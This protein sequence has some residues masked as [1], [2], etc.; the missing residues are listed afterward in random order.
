MVAH[1]VRF[2]WIPAHMTNIHTLHWPMALY[3][4]QSPL[5]LRENVI[6]STETEEAVIRY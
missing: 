3:I 1:V 5:L 2:H 6:V 4:R